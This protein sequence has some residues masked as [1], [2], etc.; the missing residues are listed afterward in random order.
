[1]RNKNVLIGLAAV[2]MAGL[3]PNKTLA[4]SAQITV[5]FEHTRISA[6][7]PLMGKITIRN[8]GQ[9]PIPIPSDYHDAIIHFL[10]LEVT[11]DQQ[12]KDLRCTLSYHGSYSR[13]DNELLPQ[14]QIETYFPFWCDFEHS[15]FVFPTVGNYAV[16]LIWTL[17]HSDEKVYSAEF[18]ITVF[19]ETADDK[20]LFAKFPD[21]FKRALDWP[22][23]RWQQTIGAEHVNVHESI[24]VA[25]IESMIRQDLSD[26]VER[27]KDEIEELEKLL[28]E[29]PRATVA[30]YMA[31]ALG[32]AYQTQFRGTVT[33]QRLHH[34]L[35]SWQEK[36]DENYHNAKRLFLM[37][38]KQAD[39]F[40][41]PKGAYG[42]AEMYLYKGM[43]T[44]EWEEA[45]QQSKL[46]QDK[47]TAY[48][49]KGELLHERFRRELSKAKT[50]RDKLQNKFS[51]SEE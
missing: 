43:L 51:A 8:I 5:S 17:P 32:D 22:E 11:H 47:Y 28:Q 36:H 23:E 20:I 31:Y 46:L 3:G 15:Q 29:N 18:H 1:M 34:K 44:G 48:E 38:S 40:I 24:Q 16:R 4:Q 9:E 27:R 7:Q 14:Q 26:H 41:A 49:I 19:P 13:F 42:L 25:F 30:P 12:I 33:K 39:N 37:T 2:L 50:K 45:E 6:K 10:H 35:D 21:F